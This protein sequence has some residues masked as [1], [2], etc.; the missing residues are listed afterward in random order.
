[1]PAGVDTFSEKMK[2]SRFMASECSAFC[3]EDLRNCAI[4]LGAFA[5]ACCRDSL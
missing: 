2:S 1:M 5:G 4:P 3:S